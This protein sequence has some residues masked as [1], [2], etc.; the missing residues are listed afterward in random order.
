MFGN[1][2]FTPLILPNRAISAPR[3]AA[4]ILFGGGPIDAAAQ[5]YLHPSSSHVYGLI[6]GP[7][8]GAG[9]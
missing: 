7:T 2:Q 1:T 5:R 8:L 6:A 9:F 4:G 3:R